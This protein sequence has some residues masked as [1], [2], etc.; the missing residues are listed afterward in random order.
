[1]LECRVSRAGGS[2]SATPVARQSGLDESHFPSA[3]HVHRMF[4]VAVARLI[5]VTAGRV[6]QPLPMLQ[7][8]R[9]WREKAISGHPGT[10]VLKSTG[11]P[12]SGSTE[13]DVG[14]QRNVSHSADLKSETPSCVC[15]RNVHE[16]VQCQLA[17]A[18]R[19]N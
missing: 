18:A 17:S 11:N 1:M 6:A 7:L 2:K 13:L 8:Q 5:I 4:P 3:T 9:R 12:A 16:H 14:L 19:V 15:S 10:M